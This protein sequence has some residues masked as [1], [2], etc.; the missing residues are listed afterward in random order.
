MYRNSIRQ[1]FKDSTIIDK[2]TTVSYTGTDRNF[3]KQTT[4]KHSDKTEQMFS[5]QNSTEQADDITYGISMELSDDYNKSLPKQDVNEYPD[6][7]GNEIQKQ[8]T[9]CTTHDYDESMHTLSSIQGPKEASKSV[10]NYIDVNP[11]PM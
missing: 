6:D 9:P 3:I 2:L 7:A 5:T 10:Y 11:N 4:G 1:S 8:N